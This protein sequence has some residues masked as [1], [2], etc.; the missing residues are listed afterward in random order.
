M[1]IGELK[2]FSGRSNPELTQSICKHLG[3]PLGKCTIKT[4]PD[5][6][7]FV[8]IDENIRGKDVFLVQSTC[9]PAND[10]LM[11]LLILIE[12]ARRASAGRITAVIPFYGYARQDRKD[13]PRVPITAKLVANLL[14]AAGAD[15]VLALDLHAPQIQGFFDIPFDHLH[16]SPVF[17][18]HIRA[19][20]SKDLVI[21]S[22]DVGGLK[23]ASAYADALG[24]PLGFVAK[25]R[26]GP[27]SVTA[28]NIVGEVEGKDV[29]L[30]D[31]MTETAGT[32]TAAA[33]LIKQH[34][35]RRVFAAVTHC[36]LG[37]MGRKRLGEGPI[38]ELFTTDSTPVDARGLPITV[39]SIAKLLGDGIKRIHTHE[40]VSSLFTIKGY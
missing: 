34:G 37:E 17:I 6:E 8:R 19:I 5:G 39:L 3:I 1:E 25:K 2:I 4:F 38:D 12:T 30:I 31:D 10:H 20:D 35:A 24:L 9:Y 13:Q 15:R 16:A 36:M 11:E 23:L 7:F 27:E 26:T 33:N 32:L 14:V 18:D 28:M 22:P 40:S 29:L 21:F